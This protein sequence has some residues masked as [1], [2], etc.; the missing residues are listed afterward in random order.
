MYVCESVVKTSSI[1]S[2]GNLSRKDNIKIKTD[3]SYT[4]F[5]KIYRPIYEPHLEKTFF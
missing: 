2:K 1:L 3:I 5:Q 4:V